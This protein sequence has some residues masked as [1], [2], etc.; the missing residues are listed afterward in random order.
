[1]APQQTEVSVA[2]ESGV[3][4]SGKVLTADGSPEKGAA[5]VSCSQGGSERVPLDDQGEFHISRGLAGGVCSVQLE[6]FSSM[7]TFEHYRMFWLDPQQ[8]PTLEFRAPA[9]R[10]PI[11]VR[12]QGKGKPKKAVLFVGELP[13][14]VNLSQFSSLSFMP[15]F[16]GMLESMGHRA[17]VEEEGG[18]RFEDLG[19][20]HY[21]LVVL[22]H[23]AAFRAPL[24]V[25][26]QEQTFTV[27]IPAQLTPFYR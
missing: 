6:L 9:V 18:F 11:H 22:M 27:D 17:G 21:T 2:L 26:E 24:T 4:L 1:V 16:G 8:P 12:F 20:G 5:R 14:Q 13:S 19:P 15:T 25:G 3:G 10:N 7:P 23:Q